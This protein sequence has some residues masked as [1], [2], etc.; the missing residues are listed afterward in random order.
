MFDHVLDRSL[1]ICSE[2][3]LVT[4]STQLQKNG[5]VY[6]CYVHA[7]FTWPQMQSFCYIDTFEFGKTAKRRNK[8]THVIDFWFEVLLT[9]SSQNRSEFVNL[10]E[11]RTKMNHV[12]HFV[13]YDSYDSG[14]MIDH[15][16]RLRIQNE[17]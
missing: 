15:S 4:L 9:N 10:P 16:N 2:S 8:I 1:N 6:L 11:L 5:L 3:A 13:S 7:I 12:G 14:S 17:K